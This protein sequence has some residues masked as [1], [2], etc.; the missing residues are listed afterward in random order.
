MNVIRFHP[1]FFRLVDLGSRHSVE[2]VGPRG[3][4]MGWDNMRYDYD[5][6][7]NYCIISAT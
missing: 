3:T 5:T 6:R 4:G 1:F 7:V 2:V